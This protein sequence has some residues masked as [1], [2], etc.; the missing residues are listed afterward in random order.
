MTWLPRYTGSRNRDAETRR[1]EGDAP[2]SLGNTLGAEQCPQ[3]GSD[4]G[5]KRHDR[6]ILVEWPVQWKFAEVPY[7]AVED[8]I[9]ADWIW[10]TCVACN[11][12]RT[13]PEGFRPMTR[14]EY[15]EFMEG[16]NS[17]QDT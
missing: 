13:I 11:Q 9:D 6:D 2:Q 14:A 12:A 15:N 3:C 10:L 8:P 5:M 17:G 4:F 7:R 16:Y 1:R